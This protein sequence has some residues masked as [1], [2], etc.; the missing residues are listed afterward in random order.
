MVLDVFTCVEANKLIVE[1]LLLIAHEDKVIISDFGVLEGG[2]GLKG[3]LVV[4]LGTLERIGRIDNLLKYILED[5]FSVVVAGLGRF[6][7][8]LLLLWLLKE[9][10]LKLHQ[11]RL[12]GVARCP[13]LVPVGARRLALQHVEANGVAEHVFVH[14]GKNV[15]AH[16]DCDL[17]R[18]YRVVGREGKLA[19]DHCALVDRVGRPTNIGVPTEVVVVEGL[20]SH[21]NAGRVTAL[22]LLVVSHKT[23]DSILLPAQN[24]VSEH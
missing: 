2:E 8:L 9:E 10:G 20:G 11:N 16:K 24:L 1:H 5:V 15:R 17:G 22:K 18:G 6:L 21:A 4:T 23:L 3:S 12:D 7:D 19:V 13:A 14:T